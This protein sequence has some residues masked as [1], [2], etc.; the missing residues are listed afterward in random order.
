VN[1]GTGAVSRSTEKSQTTDS[2]WSWD[3]RSFS[4]IR[5]SPPLAHHR[6]LFL[7]EI[8]SLFGGLDFFFF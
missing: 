6:D 7:Q 1:T 2:T 8:Q 5:S 3:E 4:I